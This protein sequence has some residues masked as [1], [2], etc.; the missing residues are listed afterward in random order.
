MANNSGSKV[1][2]ITVF[3]ILFI[4]GS[5]ITMCDSNSSNKLAKKAVKLCNEEKY[6][7]AVEKFTEADS[8]SKIE[9][10]VQLYYFAQA[11]KNTGNYT[12]YEQNMQKSYD[13]YSKNSENYTKAD[14]T[15]VQE[16]KTFHEEESA[17]KRAQQSEEEKQSQISSASSGSASY[18]PYMSRIEELNNLLEETD[19][20]ALKESYEEQLRELGSAAA[21]Y[22]KAANGYDR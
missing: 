5:I 13:E 15:I 9:D 16:L 20:P 18:N 4:L 17:K 14:K 12:G 6:T 21:D 7:E 10:A 1:G 8:K 22:D 3:L 19:D 11:L 2:C